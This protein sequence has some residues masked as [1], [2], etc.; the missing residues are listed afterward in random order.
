M[1]VAVVSPAHH[2]RGGGRCGVMVAVMDAGLSRAA[3]EGDRRGDEGDGDSVNGTDHAISWNGRRGAP[4]ASSF[5]RGP[6]ICRLI[7]C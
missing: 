2:R 5:P 3:G 6:R 7:I 4:W 1:A